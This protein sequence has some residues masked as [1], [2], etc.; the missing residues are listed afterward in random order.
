MFLQHVLPALVTGI[1]AAV[2]EVMEKV[3]RRL[4][5]DGESARVRRAQRN[6]LLLKCENYKL[7]Q[8]TRRETTRIVGLP[9]EK[10]EDLEK[11][12]LELFEAEGAS[13]EADD[14]AVVH[15]T[16]RTGRGPRPVLARFVSRKKKKEVM[17]KR[18]N[19]K[20]KE[21]YKS[22]Y[23]NDDLTVLRSKLF[24]YVKDSKR[25]DRVWT[26]DGKIHIS[27]KVPLGKERNV[28]ERPMVIE[29]ADDLFRIGFDS[30]DAEALGL[31]EWWVDDDRDD[32]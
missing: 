2:A 15:R 16:G 5:A 32:E 19:L 26:V 3:L 1:A 17:V 20:D 14:L 9:E 6:S 10:G 29:N 7:E 31:S 21:Q 8:Y 27:K 18:K 22:V 23:V 28:T 24:K 11:K 12:V 13:I 25:F 30:V 4:Q